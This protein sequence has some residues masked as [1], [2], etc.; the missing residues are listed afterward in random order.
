MVNYKKL[1][2]SIHGKILV[3]ND[4]HHID[5][6]RENNNIDNLISIPKKI[7]KLIHKYWGYVNREEL[8]KVMVFYKQIIDRDNCSVG[9][10][11]AILVKHINTK[12]KDK[13]SIQCRVSI[14][15]DITRYQSNFD[16]RDG[17][18]GMY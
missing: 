2:E 12:K 7:H 4:V 17:K 5:W 6:N 3:G 1:Y 14:E 8:D 13:L 18:G 15:Y 9:Y 10:L 11:N 16:W